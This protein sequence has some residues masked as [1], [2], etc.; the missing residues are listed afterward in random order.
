MTTAASAA[1][2]AGSAPSV[3]AVRSPARTVTSPAG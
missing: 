1:G 2:P 3:D